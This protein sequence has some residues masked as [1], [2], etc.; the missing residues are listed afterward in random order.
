MESMPGPIQSRDGKWP[1]LGAEKELRPRQLAR[2][3]GLGEIGRAGWA[4]DP[5]TLPPEAIPRDRFIGGQLRS[6]CG[7]IAPFA[8]SRSAPG[9]RPGNPEAVCALVGAGLFWHQP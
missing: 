3:L 2:A 7:A 1:P 5:K 9:N 8:P 6:A 4:L